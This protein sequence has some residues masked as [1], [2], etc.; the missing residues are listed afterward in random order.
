MIIEELVAASRVNFCS[1]RTIL[2]LDIG[3]KPRR[4][5]GYR[6][7]TVHKH[8][9]SIRPEASE[10]ARQPSHN[11][12]TCPPAEPPSAKLTPSP[13][14][15]G[16]LPTL[17]LGGPPARRQTGRVRRPQSHPQA[18][19]AWDHGRLWIGSGSLDRTAVGID[20]MGADGVEG[21]C[22][23]TCSSMATIRAAACPSP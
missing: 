13:G 7:L 6:R 11:A 20:K 14:D 23:R 16:D 12:G 22:A 18:P 17:S 3:R 1:A 5:C 8:R 10:G 9:R 2:R 15:N 21:G 19:P 4:L